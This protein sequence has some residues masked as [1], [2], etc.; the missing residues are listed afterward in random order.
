M[1]YYDYN[2]EVELNYG[3]I[4]SIVIEN[5]MLLD[6]FVVSLYNSLNKK[7]DKINVLENFEKIDYIKMTDVIF[8]PL[9][10]TY[11]KR[12]VQ[13]KLIQNILVEID[14]SDLSYKFIE[15]CSNF[16][17][18]LDKIRM[19]SEYEID[20]DEN[21]EMRKLLQCFDIHLQEPEGNF[22][23]RFVEYISVMLK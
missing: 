14:G 5:P 22:V 1:I 6:S 3:E 7:E 11:D 17:E 2:I 9:E 16:L 12:D 20:F 23:E 4:T 19:N 21:F 18:N 15:I 13:K 8:S 10:L